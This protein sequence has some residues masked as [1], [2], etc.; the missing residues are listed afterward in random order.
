MVREGACITRI[1]LDGR[2]IHLPERRVLPQQK[3]N[4]T[5]RIVAT[6]NNKL[7]P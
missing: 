5:S 6:L 2:V 4:K 1:W 7:F 3:N